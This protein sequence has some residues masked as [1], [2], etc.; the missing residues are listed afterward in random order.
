MSSRGERETKLSEVSFIRWRVPCLLR[1]SHAWHS[2]P[3]SSTSTC[4]HVGSSDLTP[5]RRGHKQCTEAP[6]AKP[7]RGLATRLPLRTP[8]RPCLTQHQP[9]R[10]GHHSNVFLLLRYYYT[11]WLQENVLWRTSNNSRETDV[12]FQ[13]ILNMK[14]WPLQLH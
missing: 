11:L 12:F 13:L 5:E 4:R 6:V 3:R 10:L 9:H 8:L 7:T 2:H 14:S 1:A